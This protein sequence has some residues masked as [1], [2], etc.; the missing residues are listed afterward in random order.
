V[1]CNEMQYCF[2]TKLNSGNFEQ[3]EL[4]YLYPF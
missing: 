1:I 2:L 4:K 3:L